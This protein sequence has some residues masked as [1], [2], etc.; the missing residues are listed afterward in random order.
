MKRHSSRIKLWTAGVL[1]GAFTACSQ[2]ATPVA[3]PVA[4]PDSREAEQALV[5]LAADQIDSVLSGVAASTRAVAE[6]FVQANRTTPAAAEERDG[7]A[8]RFIEKDNTV[9][10]QSWP[11]TL[12]PAPDYQSEHSSY[13]GYHGMPLDDEGYRVLEVL[14]ALTPAVRAAYRSYPYS[15]SYVTASNDMMLLYPFLTLD[16]AVNNQSPS[17]QTYYTHADFEHR[18]TGWTPPYLD[19]VG[20]GMMVTASTPAYDGDTLLGVVSHDITLAQLSHSVMERMAGDVGGTAWLVDANGLAIA[21]SDPALESELNSVNQS[22]GAAVLY[23]RRPDALAS[24]IGGKAQASQTD[25]IN[26]VTEEMLS[27]APDAGTARAVI[28]GSHHRHDVLAARS[29]VTGWLLV[30]KTPPRRQ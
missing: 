15:W 14:R 9:L 17:A 10:F 26:E 18:A 30:W 12:E 21:V 2:P 4:A 5:R 25:W 6:E 22:A 13:Y 29:K 27:R 16:E 1:M 23:Y 7:W 11:G 3:A 28:R 20:A 19:L 24:A 8:A